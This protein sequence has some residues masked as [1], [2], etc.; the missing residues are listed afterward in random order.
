MNPKDF[1]K[2]GE[3]LLF[4]KEQYVKNRYSTYEIAILLG[5]YANA[6]RRA[7]L[8]HGLVP[9]DH[10]EAQRVALQKGRHPG[11]RGKKAP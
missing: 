8:R 9:R 4:L 2:S 10:S 3:G 6:V 7:L 11:R 5:T 1:L